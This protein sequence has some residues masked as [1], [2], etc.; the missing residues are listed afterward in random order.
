MQTS[1][2]TMGGIS[3]AAVLAALLLGGGGGSSAPFEGLVDGAAN[4]Q[5]TSVKRAQPSPDAIPPVRIASRSLMGKR[6]RLVDAFF[7]IDGI[8]VAHLTAPGKQELDLAGRALDV[9]LLRGQHTLTVVLVYQ[10]RSVGLF[11]YMDSY[12]FRAVASYPFYLEK[13]PEGTPVINV[14]ARERPGAFVPLEK[15]P[16]VDI[17][18]PFGFG[19]TPMTGVNH[20]TQV[21]VVPVNPPAR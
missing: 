15:K 8:Q 7:M 3:F 17:S 13:P 20:G 18:A 5:E 2:D 10:G 14:L 1:I 6:F 21:T 4:F 11:S 9:L 19:V 12:R 16:M